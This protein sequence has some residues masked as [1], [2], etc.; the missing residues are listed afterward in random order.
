MVNILKRISLSCFFAHR[1]L[2][3]FEGFEKWAVLVR[4]FWLT[5]LGW[6]ELSVWA[7]ANG[8]LSELS[9]MASTFYLECPYG[10]A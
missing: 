7:T 4:L 8:L 6:G 2:A 9:E 5:L 3:F 10:A 1:F